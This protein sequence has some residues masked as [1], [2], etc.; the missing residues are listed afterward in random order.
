MCILA[1]L[2][3]FSCSQLAPEM[4]PEAGAAKL[5]EVI[6]DP[7]FRSL[8]SGFVSFLEAMWTQA[9]PGLPPILLNAGKRTLAAHFGSDFLSLPENR[10][11]LISETR[12]AALERFLCST[13]ANP[14]MV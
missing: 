12:K 8:G 6:I 1:H 13:A 7:T 4:G 14:G 9:I 2:A 10:P 5:S 3:P 11:N